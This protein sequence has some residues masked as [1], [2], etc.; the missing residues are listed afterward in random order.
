LAQGFDFIPLQGERDEEHQFGVTIPI[1]GWA[2]DADYFR[3]GVRNLLI[4]TPW[5]TRTSSFR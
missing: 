3:T 2:I 4:T 5:E 1:K